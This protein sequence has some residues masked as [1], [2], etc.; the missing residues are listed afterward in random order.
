MNTKKW[1]T[2]KIVHSQKR[3]I[4]NDVKPKTMDSKKWC[5]S[6]MVDTQKRWIGEDET[7]K[8]LDTQ[9]ERRENVGK[10]NG[11]QIVIQAKSDGYSKTMDR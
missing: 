10:M 3:W 2:S 1:R 9:K 4:V 7:P 5:M 8:L 11:E 6:R